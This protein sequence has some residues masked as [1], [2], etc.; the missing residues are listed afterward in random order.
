MQDICQWTTNSSTVNYSSQDAVG[1]HCMTLPPSKQNQM[2]IL[3]NI[4]GCC[5]PSRTHLAP[6]AVFSFSR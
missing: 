3:L 1:V 4:V 5:L 2:S 6:L